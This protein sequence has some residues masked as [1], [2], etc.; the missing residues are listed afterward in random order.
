MVKKRK[1]VRVILSVLLLAAVFAVQYNVYA[2]ESSIQSDINIDNADGIDLSLKAK[3]IDT[4]NLKLKV[5]NSSD[6]N[7][8]IM[9]YFFENNKKLSPNLG[10]WEEILSLPITDLNITPSSGSDYLIKN[11]VQEKNVAST[12]TDN[13]LTLTVPPN[14]EGIIS[15]NIS[16]ISKRDITIVPVMGEDNDMMPYEPVY[17]DKMLFV[18]KIASDKTFIAKYTFVDEEISPDITIDD[19]FTSQEYISNFTLFSELPVYIYDDSTYMIKAT[20]PINNG[21]VN[22][23]PQDVCF[24]KGNQK[25]EVIKEGI[26]WNNDECIAYIDKDKM[27]NASEDDFADMQVQLLFPCEGSQKEVSIDLTIKNDDNLITVPC[28]EDKITSRAYDFPKFNLATK[29]TIQNVSRHEIG[30]FVNNCPYPLNDNQYELTEDG[31]IIINTPAALIDKVEVYV[32]KQETM[33]LENCNDWE[34]AGWT[35]SSFPSNAWSYIKPDIDMSDLTEGMWEKTYMY[36]GRHEGDVVSSWMSDS[37]GNGYYFKSKWQ[38]GILNHICLPWKKFNR[39]LT[40]YY[41]PECTNYCY[42]VPGSSYYDQ[43]VPGYCSHVSRANGLSKQKEVT[44]WIQLQNID[45]S[46]EDYTSYIFTAETYPGTHLGSATTYQAQ[47]TAFMYRQYHKKVIPEEQI[48]E[49]NIIKKDE[50][51]NPLEGAQFALYEDKECQNLVASNTSDKQGK[52]QFNNLKLN[53]VYYLQEQRAPKGYKLPLNNDGSYITQ[54]IEVRKDISTNQILGLFIDNEY[55]DEKHTYGAF[56][57]D[58]E[59]NISANLN[60]YNYNSMT[61]PNTGN[62]S[63]III[64]LSGIILILIGIVYSYKYSCK[65]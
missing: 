3:D 39:D 41:D 48:F 13:M 40:F 54:S 53:Q 52:L 4:C 30:I 15:A 63:R 45:N 7:N 56:K 20:A 25:G 26:T 27:E 1:I 28:N 6:N 34:H 5:S 42:G 31:T 11:G 36:I 43:A 49:M 35:V 50:K 32:T 58:N 44:G 46:N 51:D 29:D 62:Q 14:T 65:N 10:E 60:I 16:N 21:F 22:K 33:L 12:Y 8:K 2:V 47:A 23:S 64:V 37:L 17:I 18:D 24:A 61:L 55:I 9:I 38:Y 19:I 59:N 57:I